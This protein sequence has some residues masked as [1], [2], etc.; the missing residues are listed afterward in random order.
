MFR[1]NYHIF[2]IT[3][4][5]LGIGVSSYSAETFFVYDDLGR[6][7]KVITATGEAATYSYD[8][9][10]NLLSIAR[11]TTNPVPPVITSISPDIVFTGTTVSITISGNNLIGTTDVSSS[12]AGIS[13]SSATATD[14]AIIATLSISRDTAHGTANIQV[15]TVFGTAII[16]ITVMKLTI[17]P[18][19]KT[20]L[21]GNSTDFRIE[22]SQNAPRDIN[23]SLIS[24]DISVMLVPA[25]MT[26][27]A[28]QNTLTFTATAL[29]EGTTVLRV[30]NGAA[31]ASVYVS[32]PFTGDATLITSAVSV[33]VQPSEESA[34]LDK[35]PL[36]SNAVSV[37][38]SVSSQSSPVDKGPFLTIPISVL[39]SSQPQAAV[40]DKGP[41]LSLPIS[42]DIESQTVP[43]TGEIGP[44]L[45]QPVSVQK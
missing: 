22:L 26:F 43:T 9:V 18:P 11:Q 41:F 21:P 1:R 14:T 20:M 28:G 27:N 30:G 19:I 36:M 23:I 33:L 39:L 31:S 32:Q 40:M 35:G 44:V 5:F 2:L 29:T 3:V 8:E 12:A 45:S 15:T 10:G 13:I 34:I 17:T 24:E 6:L 25:S 38:I 37:I 16:S 42:V 4:L 7:N